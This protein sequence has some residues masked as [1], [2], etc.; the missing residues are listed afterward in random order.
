MLS[1]DRELKYEDTGEVGRCDGQLE[2]EL[3][4][5]PTLVEGFLW[6][7]AVPRGETEDSHRPTFEDWWRKCL[8]GD[9]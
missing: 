2:R 4:L 5:V 6:L 8:G 7:G 3:A 1:L 9:E